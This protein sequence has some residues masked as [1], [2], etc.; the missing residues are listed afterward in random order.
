MDHALA[1]LDEP[2]DPFIVTASRRMLARTVL[3]VQGDPSTE[4]GS[5]QSCVSR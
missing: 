3:V 1:E 5:E 4:V 2:C